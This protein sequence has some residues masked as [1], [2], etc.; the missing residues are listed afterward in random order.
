MGQ[1]D[2]KWL[3]S[4]LGTLSKVL[5]AVHLVLL[6]VCIET[7]TGPAIAAQ[8]ACAGAEDWTALYKHADA[9]L[10]QVKKEGGRGCR[11]YR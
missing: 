7:K 6:L 4:R 11:L 5:I 3:A 10:Y 2:E 9:A 1:P 8:A